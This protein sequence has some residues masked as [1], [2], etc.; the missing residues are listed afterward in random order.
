MCLL[1]SC[2]RTTTIKQTNQPNKPNQPNQT[3]QNQPDFQTQTHPIPS[4][5]TANTMRGSGRANNHASKSG[6]VATGSNCDSG[7]IVLSPDVKTC[8]QTAAPNGRCSV[9]ERL[10]K[11]GPWARRIQ[12]HSISRVRTT[13]FMF[14]AAQK[15]FTFT[16]RKKINLWKRLIQSWAVP[17]PKRFN[18]AGFSHSM[19]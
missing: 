2:L 13:L 1:P 15:T 3:N 11:N 7:I 6:S 18:R 10:S 4:N 12:G 16:L 19:P 5:Q 9:D 14:L 17:P 8:P